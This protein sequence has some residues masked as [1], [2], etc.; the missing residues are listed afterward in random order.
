MFHPKITTILTV[1]LKPNFQVVYFHVD[2]QCKMNMKPGSKPP[3]EL[4]SFITRYMRCVWIYILHMLDPKLY[5]KYHGPTPALLRPQVKIS[6]RIKS[7]LGQLL[8]P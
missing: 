2:T 3:R 4:V 6:Q 1:V 8:K 7:L 5:R